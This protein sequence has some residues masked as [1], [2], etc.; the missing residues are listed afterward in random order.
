MEVT[1]L[2]LVV[3]IDRLIILWCSVAEFKEKF[4]LSDWDIFEYLSSLLL[5]SC[6]K[7]FILVI[8]HIQLQLIHNLY[9]LS[10]RSETK[11]VMLAAFHSYKVLILENL[12]QTMEQ[13][14]LQPFNIF[15]LLLNF[16]HIKIHTMHICSRPTK[17][18]TVISSRT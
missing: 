8:M 6:A 18:L 16:L 5:S 1:C 11:I 15:Y 3:C 13:S 9:W 10:I 17:I 12:C 14:C 4:H 2:K 7:W